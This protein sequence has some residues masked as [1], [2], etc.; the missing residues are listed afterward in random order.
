MDRAAFTALT[1]A[2]YAAEL[3]SVTSNN[4]AN[5]GTSGFREQLAFFR[6]VPLE[7]E[8]APTRTFA[9]GWTPY[10]KLAP[11]VLENTGNP[12]NAA[13]DGEGWFVVQRRDGTQGLTR[14]GSFRVIDRKLSLSDGMPVIG[15]DGPITLPDGAELDIADDGT[16]NAKFPT[17]PVTV[18]LL[19]RL[20]VVNPPANTLLRDGDG[21]F[22]TLNKRVE[23]LPEDP[24]IKVRGRT[25]ETSNVNSANA[26]LQI[27]VDSRAFDMN[28]KVV[29]T[30]SEN[31]KAANAMIGRAR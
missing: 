30:V 11:G 23:E 25:L 19:G 9:L 21:F 31:E 29:Q 16:V 5:A 20:K 10:A 14:S 6:S 22:V 24:T 26:M 13:V 1:G 3:L 8:G 12:F 17:N 28:M 4:L 15:V 7:G 27:I 18:Q 2:K